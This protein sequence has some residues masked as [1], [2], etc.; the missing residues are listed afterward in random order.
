MSPTEAPTNRQG[1]APLGR[2]E[3]NK[4][5]VKE[6][7]YSSAITLFAEQ[8]YDETSIDEIVERADVARGTFFNY[9]QRKEDLL[10]AWGEKRRDA[11]LATLAADGCGADSAVGQL[12]HCMTTLS[13]I[14]EGHRQETNSLL[15]AWVRAGRPLLEDPYLADLFARI[16]GDGIRSGEFHTRFTADQI[17]H[18][19]RD[20]YLGA[21]YRWCGRPDAAPDQLAHELMSTL[22]LVLDGVQAARDPRD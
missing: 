17:G 1:A 6:R 15:M 9:F 20:L 10:G 21:L 3:R 16:A 14:N 7:L 13:R 12:R 8:G 22:D 11:L 2:R 19:L 18:A 5:R 4:L